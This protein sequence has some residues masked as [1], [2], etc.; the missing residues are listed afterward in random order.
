MRGA[1]GSPTHL[2]KVA[3][4]G[5]GDNSGGVPTTP[6][7]GNCWCRLSHSAPFASDHPLAQLGLEPADAVDAEASALR[8]M[9]MAFQLPSRG[10]AQPREPLA[11]RLTDD[12][13][14]VSL[15]V[16]VGLAWHPV[17]HVRTG[18]RPRERHAPR[19]DT[20]SRRPAAGRR[21]EGGTCG[22]WRVAVALAGR[23]GVEGQ[24]GY[25]SRASH[26]P[27]PSLR[28]LAS[29]ASCCTSRSIVMR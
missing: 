22:Q 16:V 10:P 8:E 17:G 12:A 24:Q 23:S 6:L 19:A 21:R 29:S 27:R 9:A 13:I 20:A 18:Q 28:P 5:A 11:F 26:W 7:G 2:I 15:H 3:A 14:H 4:R 1:A 25:R